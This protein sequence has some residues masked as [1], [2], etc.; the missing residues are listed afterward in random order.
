MPEKT[1][2]AAEPTCCGEPMVHNSGTGKYECAAAFF[3]LVDDKVITDDGFLLQEALSP[4]DRDLY[5]H[6][7]SSVRPDA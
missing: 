2:P 6:W 7:Q 1:P 3:A 5:D 4:R